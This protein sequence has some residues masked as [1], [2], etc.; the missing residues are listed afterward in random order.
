VPAWHRRAGRVLAVA[1]LL[2]AI[3]AIWMTLF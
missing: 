2:V 3:S 1:G